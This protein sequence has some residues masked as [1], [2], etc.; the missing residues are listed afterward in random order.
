MILWAM[1]MAPPPL[2]S[3]DPSQL[4]SHQEYRIAGQF[5]VSLFLVT[6]GT[7]GIAAS[8]VVFIS[9]GLYIIHTCHCGLQSICE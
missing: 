3:S 7:P 1:M 9:K 8:L 6:D 4:V 5:L 2:A